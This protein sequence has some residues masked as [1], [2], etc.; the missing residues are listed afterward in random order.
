MVDGAGLFGQD[1]RRAGF[2]DEDAVGLVDD[3]QVQPAQQ[4]GRAYQLR[5]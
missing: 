4:R 2:V 3:G 1:Q 5:A